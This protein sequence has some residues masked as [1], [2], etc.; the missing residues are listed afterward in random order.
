MTSSRLLRILLILLEKGRVT[1]PELAE[2]FETSVRTIYRDIDALSAAGIPVYTVQGQ[3][4]GI[5]I[6]QEYT[7]NRVLLSN[8]EQE[9][10][11]MA[12]QEVSAAERHQSD[13]LLVKLGG[14]FKT[15]PADWLEIDFSQWGMESK[16][17][18]DPLKQAILNKQLVGF[19]YANRKGEQEERIVEP[20]KLIFKNKDWYLQAFCQLRQDF[21]LFK[22]LRMKQLQPLEATFQRKSVPELLTA[23]SSA[24]DEKISVKLLFDQDTAYKVYDHYEEFIQQQDGRLQVKIDLPHNDELYN[25]L[26][27]LGDRVE[28]AA[29]MEVRLELAKRIKKILDFY[30]T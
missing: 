25:F 6:N 21:R 29:P 19:F 22:L 2:Q 10:I 5:F 20:H 28:V 16:Q 27:S 8:E 3:G 4:G 12:L 26:L 15:P 18:F 1:A 7:L 13:E 17:L 24:A 11:L 23:Q 14:L 30:E 9:K